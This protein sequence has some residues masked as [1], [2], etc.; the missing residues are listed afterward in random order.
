MLRTSSDLLFISVVACLAGLFAGAGFTVPVLQALFGLPLALILPG[1]A[2]TAI[3][4]PP[5]ALDPN[6][7]TL[8]GPERLLF[9]VGL[10]LIVTILG[11]LVLHWTHLGLT[12]FT[13]AIL[14]IAITLVAS[15]IAAIRRNQET[16]FALPSIGLTPPQIAAIGLAVIIVMG[17]I[18]VARIPSPTRGLEGYTIL[19]LLPSA[20]DPTPGVRVGINSD[21]FSPVDYR[22]VLT[23]EAKP[24]QA[25]ETIHL[26]PG[27]NW[28]TAVDLPPDATGLVSGVLYRLDNP[29]TVYRQVELWYR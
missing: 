1:Y 23:L 4:F 19:W 3:F 17:A 14:L 18:A 20:T 25:W 28:E 27:E 24:L 15:L 9:S 11:S 16:A 26:E 7:H 5:R 8:G 12:T 13:W 21:E 29:N 10:S 6:E 2:L 22:L